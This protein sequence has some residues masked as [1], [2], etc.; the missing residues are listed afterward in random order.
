MTFRSYR[1][2]TAA[3]LLPFIT[4]PAQAGSA[5]M[6]SI[7]GVIAHHAGVFFEL[8]SPRTAPPAC[9]SQNRWLINSATNQG[10]AMIAVL[11]TAQMQGKR[12]GVVGMGSCDVWT[13]TETVDHF[14]VEN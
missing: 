10:Q 1:L 4:V 2:A 3:L 12:V 11:L 14:I 13:D 8:S 9:A 6:G 5:G 7:S